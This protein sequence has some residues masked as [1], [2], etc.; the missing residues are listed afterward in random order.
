M[1]NEI[2]AAVRKNAVKI[3]EELLV[4]PTAEEAADAIESPDLE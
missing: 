1:A 2:E 4:G 3:V